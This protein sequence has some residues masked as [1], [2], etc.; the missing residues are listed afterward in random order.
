MHFFNTVNIDEIFKDGFKIYKSTFK[1]F[2]K[3]ALLAVTLSYLVSIYV[4]I[5]D[6]FLFDYDIAYIIAIVLLVLLFLPIAYYS[7]RMNMTAAGKFKA[8]IEGQP[9]NFKEKFK[10]SKHDFWRVFFVLA[11]KF[12]IRLMMLLALLPT[13]LYIVSLASPT[14]LVM[15]MKGTVVFIVLFVTLLIAG[16]LLY[17]LTRLEFAS[18]IIYWHVDTD[19]SDLSAS[20]IM[21]K[22]QYFTKLKLMIVAHIPNIVLNIITVLNFIYNFQ[23]FNPIMRWGYILGLI[24]FNTVTFSWSMSYYYPMFKQMKAFALQKEKIVD[25]EGREWLTF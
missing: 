14:S 15:Q 11:A 1:T 16:G 17:L 23:S 5:L 13:I 24:A 22:S 25:E 6:T 20:M 9:F 10:E 7:I 4:G 18:L 21:T 12:L 8:L 3:Y 19:K 2:L